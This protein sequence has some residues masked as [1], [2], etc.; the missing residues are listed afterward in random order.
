MGRGRSGVSS[1]GGGSGIPNVNSAYT[2][3]DG[4]GNTMEMYFSKMDGQNYYSR[5]IGETPNP[6]PNNMTPSQMVGRA[7][8][9]GY[10][11][12]KKSNKTLKEEY[13]AYK[14]DKAET[15]RVLDAAYVSDSNFVKGSRAN[16]IG[17][18]A[19]ARRR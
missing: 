11:V 14:K 15:Q 16:R 12:D 17:N 8:A 5:G 7:R 1:G 4:S 3:T 6:T 10:T 2:F 9:N 19:A 18:R 13:D